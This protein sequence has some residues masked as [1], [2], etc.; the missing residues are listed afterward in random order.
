M[1]SVC[2]HPD[3]CVGCRHCEVACALEHSSHTDI[4]SYALGKPETAGYVQ[5]DLQGQGVNVCL[6]TEGTEFAGREE[7]EYL[8][9][10][11]GEK[12][13]ADAYIA[14][15]GVKPNVGL[16]GETDIAVEEGILVDEYLQS[17]H[18]GIFACGDVA[19][20]PEL[21]SGQRQVL[22]L[23]PVAV[24]QGWTAGKNAAG[25]KM[26][27]QP[28]MSMN[29]LK[30]LS[31]PLVVAGRQEGKEIARKGRGWLAPK[32]AQTKTDR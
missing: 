9:T 27:Y 30:G 31:F 5:E 19:Q 4:I 8:L 11:K 2:L 13:C 10:S 18:S 26:V 1:Q 29:S 14:A 24:Q 7:V 25:R 20:A 3:R 6:H 12:L 22:G 17:S 21:L 15:T 16:L 32:N 23:Y 28:Q